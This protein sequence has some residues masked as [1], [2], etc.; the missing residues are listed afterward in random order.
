M[1]YRGAPGVWAGFIANLVAQH[2][3]LI[4]LSYAGFHIGWGWRL[5]QGYSANNTI[6]YNKIQNHMQALDDGG[7]LYTSGPQP[8]TI[9]HDNWVSGRGT[10]QHGRSCGG[11]QYQDDGSAYITL[12]DNVI[13]EPQEGSGNLCCGYFFSGGSPYNAPTTH[14]IV[15]LRTYT[16]TLKLLNA[17][18]NTTISETVDCSQGWPP[19]ALNIMRNAGARPRPGGRLASY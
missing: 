2:N 1:V 16:N 4:N 15:V 7:G 17:T 12:H 14:N 6:A 13:D 11:G 8:G 3:T 10:P 18:Y 5:A 9:I 19:D